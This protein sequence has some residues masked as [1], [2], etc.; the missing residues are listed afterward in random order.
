[1]NH[2]LLED[3]K[4]EFF[5]IK[6]E[7]L[8]SYFYK[9]NRE[10]EG[11]ELSASLMKL[12]SDFMLRNLATSIHRGI[13]T[14]PG[15][16]KL[17]REKYGS[18]TLIPDDS[19]KNKGNEN[20]FVEVNLSSDKTYFMHL[21]EHFN[22]RIWGILLILSIFLIIVAVIEDKENIFEIEASKWTIGVS[23][24][25]MITFTCLISICIESRKHKSLLNMIREMESKIESTVI[26]DGKEY[27]IPQSEVL[28]GDII[29]L[30]GG[31][32]VPADCIVIEGNLQ[33]QVDESYLTPDIVPVPKRP[34]K[35][36]YHE[37]EKPDENSDSSIDLPDPFLLASTLVVAGRM[38]ALVCA[39]GNNTFLRTKNLHSPYYTMMGEEKTL[40]ESRMDRIVNIFGR[41]GF[42][43]MIIILVT[44]IFR[45]IS[46]KLS[47]RENNVTVQNMSVFGEIL[48]IAAYILVLCAMFI[49]IN[50]SKAV[51]N[52]VIYSISE[53]FK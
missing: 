13:S 49:P 24:L 25:I 35:Y 15:E 52:T 28:V 41:I 1:M 44:I 2:P 43:F 22:D 33:A 34:L 7:T 45:L 9:D 18:N 20:E 30:S 29:V 8:M 17:R 14:D 36:V 23:L 32:L 11:A 19:Y 16:M 53:L 40:L 21:K 6:K 37:F 31:D 38:K 51:N 48:Y 4:E 47:Q 10:K 3:F 42:V 12:N 26:R 50:L 5:T 46:V 27:N 39:V